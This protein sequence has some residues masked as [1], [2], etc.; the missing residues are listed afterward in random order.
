MTDPATLQQRLASSDVPPRERDV[1]EFIVRIGLA[2]HG[3]GAHAH[4]VERAMA[5]LSRRF[6]LEGQ[7]FAMTTSIHVAFGPLGAQTVFLVRT[8]PGDQDLGRLAALDALLVEAAGTS[9]P[10]ERAR[11]QL[12]A[13][14]SARRPR[15]LTIEL[16]SHAL[17]AAAACV[18]LG[19]GAREV[20]AATALGLV[21][22]AIARILG[23]SAD[24]KVLAEAVAGFV[25]GLAAA[26]LAAHVAGLAIGKVTLA[27]IIYLLPGF[28]LTTAVTEIATRHL[29][30]GTARFAGACAVLLAL[31]FGAALG[32]QIG[33]ATFG[34]P[35]PG[36]TIEAL[37]GW[38]LALALIA[39][40]SAYAILLRVVRRDVPLVFAACF[41]AFAGSRLGAAALG[42]E[43]GTFCGALL[44]GIFAN[45]VAR[46][47]NRPASI[48]FVPG[49][50][51]LVPGSLG[52]ASLEALIAHDLNGGLQTAFRMILVA[53]SLAAG[54]LLA[55]VVM[56]SRR[57]L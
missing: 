19:G 51:L 35:A 20:V 29:A 8:E 21:T 27:G 33:E 40:P 49:L 45:T 39:A 42:P 53:T 55:N 14:L 7:F 52:F 54:V 43:L 1:M 26:G 30:S 11:A 5:A 10:L 47:L 12:D 46:W 4:R 36:V 37:P 13:I 44:V 25:A 3:H 48:P 9:L 6:G 17:A 2:L 22:G 38:S 18:F 16:A 31:A 28:T 57:G 56:P 15:R 41:I 24:T 32:W 50:F 34:A 23:S